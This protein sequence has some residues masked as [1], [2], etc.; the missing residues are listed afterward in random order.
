MKTKLSALS[1]SSV[2]S[3]MPETQ[4]SKHRR[5]ERASAEIAEIK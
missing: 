1:E 5:E 3:A 2:V 4:N